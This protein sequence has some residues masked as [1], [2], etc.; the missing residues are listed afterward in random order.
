MAIVWTIDKAPVDSITIT[1]EY[2]AN[3]T[4]TAGNILTK[5][6]AVSD[7]KGTMWNLSR[8]DQYWDLPVSVREQI[9]DLVKTASKGLSQQIAETTEVVLP[10]T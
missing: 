8:Q 1:V 7:A 6:R 3:G 2:D 4:P 9:R 5:G 10:T